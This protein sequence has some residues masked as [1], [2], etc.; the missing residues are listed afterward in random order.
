MVEWLGNPQKVQKKL[1]PASSSYWLRFVSC[2]PLQI[3]FTTFGFRC[4]F[5]CSGVW[6]PDVHRQTYSYH[7]YDVMGSHHNK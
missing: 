6:G 2:I 3:H 5:K 7:M 1:M 4:G